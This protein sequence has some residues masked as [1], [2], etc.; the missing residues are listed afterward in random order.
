MKELI[1]G[2]KNCFNF[3]GKATIREYRIL[4]LA[5]FPVL[6]I[7]S[8]YPFY[9]FNWIALFS[10]VVILIIFLLPLSS[11]TA[12]RLRDAGESSWWTIFIISPFLYLFL[13]LFLMFKSSEEDNRLDLFYIG[14]PQSKT[15]NRTTKYD[16][17][18]PIVN[19]K[20]NNKKSHIKLENLLFE[21]ENGNAIAQL[22]LGNLYRVGGD[23]EKNINKALYWYKKSA[24]QDYNLAQ[25]NL[26]I[27]YIKGIGV[28][29][30]KEK[31]VYW[32]N[33]SA[34]NGLAMA[35]Y[36]LGIY[37]EFEKNEQIAK[38]IYKRSQNLGYNPS[39][40]LLL[41]NVC[42]I[43]E[44][45]RSNIRE[46]LK[47]YQKAA[48]QGDVSAQFLLGRALYVH[49]EWS[50]DRDNIVKQAK[51]WLEKAACGGDKDAKAYLL[52][53]NI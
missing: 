11:V 38:E 44:K 35:Q 4:F 50:G 47:Y 36:N 12:R 46:A 19:S 39:F 17:F 5:I 34:E 31:A 29:A 45:A 27:A 18:Y 40:K 14:L 21:A 32:L 26:F 30:D 42:T 41:A 37:Y 16:D 49:Q 13:G 2:F 43:D 6:F 33:K 24:E 22:E 20:Y 9:E 53:I 52:M 23:V 15:N 28:E 10:C 48:E 51:Y 25:F 1:S 8:F 7:A 3:K